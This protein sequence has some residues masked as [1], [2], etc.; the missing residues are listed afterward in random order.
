MAVDWEIAEAFF[1]TGVGV[2]VICE[3]NSGL[4]W[5]VLDQRLDC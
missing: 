1:P 5:S 3:I 4:F 2:S